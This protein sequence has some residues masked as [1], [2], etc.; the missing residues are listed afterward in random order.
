MQRAP[1]SE[2]IRQQI[3]GMLEEGLES[4]DDPLGKLIQL[5]A[6]LVVQEALESETTKE[7]ERQQLAP[8]RQELG[9]PLHPGQ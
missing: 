4:Q 3:K 5:S 9:L 6:R 1:S 8:L 7:L 2:R